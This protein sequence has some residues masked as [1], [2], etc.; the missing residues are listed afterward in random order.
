[1]IRRLPQLAAT[2]LMAAILAGAP[3]LAQTSESEREKKADARCAAM[4]EGFKR[5]PGTDTCLEISGSVGISTG[6]GRPLGNAPNQGLFNTPTPPSTS[7]D[8]NVWQRTR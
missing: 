8:T 7:P 2:A 6:W 5:V 1:M 4:G 3:A